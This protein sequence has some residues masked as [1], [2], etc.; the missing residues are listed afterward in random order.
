MVR[1]PWNHTESSGDPMEYVLMGQFDHQRA[2]HSEHY[3]SERYTFLDV[4]GG[5]DAHETSQFGFGN[6]II[7]AT[8]DIKSGVFGGAVY[9]RPVFIDA[10]AWIT[11][12]CLLYNCRIGHHS[13]V[14][15]GSVVR[16]RTIPPY[17]IVEGNPARI[18]K[19]WNGKEWAK[20][21]P[22]R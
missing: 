7:T 8:H 4:R 17:V 10:Y 21:R 20:T 13:I 14:A 19:R 9:D 16:D 18:I 6:R 2:G 12:F 3:F 22:S 11:S 15:C 5:F 1:S